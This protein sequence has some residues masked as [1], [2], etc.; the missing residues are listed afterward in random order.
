MCAKNKFARTSSH[1]DAT[2]SE[3]LKRL[4]QSLA[5]KTSILGLVQVYPKLSLK[6]HESSLFRMNKNLRTK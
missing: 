2:F 4:I 1:R 6:L 5:P 3:V